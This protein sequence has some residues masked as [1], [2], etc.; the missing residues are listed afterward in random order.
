MLS[1]T[2]AQQI[3]GET[4]EAIGYNVIITDAEGMVIGSGDISRVGSF[5][6]ASERAFSTQVARPL[7]EIFFGRLDART[8]SSHGTAALIELTG[9]PPWL[10]GGALIALSILACIPF[11]LGIL[12][13]VRRG[14]ALLALL[15]LPL[16]IPVL[17]FGAAAVEAAAT[18]LTARPHL[19]LLL[20]LAREWRGEPEARHASALQWVRPG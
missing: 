12:R 13:C 11:A 3:A 9:V 16:F 18:G 14:G 7:V 17:I 6:E 10:A 20:Y 15:I 4:T 19:L 5:H 1:G 8:A 2:L